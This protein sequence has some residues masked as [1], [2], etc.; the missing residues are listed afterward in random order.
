MKKVLI[1]DDELL[2]RVGLKTT[3]PWEENGFC[4]VGE[5]RDGNEAIELFDKYEPDILLTDIR[6]PFI[7][8]IELVQILKERKPSLKSIILTHYDDFNY[9]KGAIKSGVEDY[10]L[11]SELTVE[12]LMETLKKYKDEIKPDISQKPV[13]D[14]EKNSLKFGLF[15]NE[16]LFKRIVIGDYNSEDELKSIAYSMEYKSNTFVIATVKLYFDYSKDQEKGNNINYEFLKKNC[17]NISRNLYNENLMYLSEDSMV[18]LFIEDLIEDSNSIL[19]KCVDCLEVVKRNLFRYLRVNVVAGL[20]D[21]GNTTYEIAELIEK[22]RTALDYCFFNSS[23]LEIFNGSMLTKTGDCPGVNKE[24]TVS[25]IKMYGTSNL[26]DYINRVFEGLFELKRKTFVREVFNE[27][28]KIA[29]DLINEFEPN[30]NNSVN[31]SMVNSEK[32]DRLITFEE[33]KDYISNLFMQ[34]KSC[35]NKDN[36]KT[37]YSY[38]VKKCMEYIENN[39][40]RNITLQDLA[41]FAGMSRCYLSYLFKEEVGVNFSSYLTNFRIEKS[42]QLLKESNCRIFEIADKVG[43]CNPYYFSRIFKETLGLS[44]KEFQ[45]L[46]S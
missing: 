7:D 38:S 31:R 22:S 14:K 43:F 36:E 9:A 27:F 3:F 44:C 37:Q 29:Q 33:V 19:N 30:V 41:H 25:S 18:F 16:F 6:M 26:K 21:V 42:K 40:N 2:V 23:T 32:F 10:I 4:V 8:G 28:L 11:K 12:N 13:K 1:A 17:E 5:A 20:S 46:N 35:L 39:Y 15:E 45:E 34:I 24:I